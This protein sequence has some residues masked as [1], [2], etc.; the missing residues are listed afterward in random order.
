MKIPQVWNTVLFVQLSNDREDFHLLITTYWHL[1]YC[2]V[3]IYLGTF[4]VNERSRWETVKR[5][6]HDEF[7][8][9][10]RCAYL[11]WEWRLIWFMQM[12]VAGIYW[13][14]LIKKPFGQK[15]MSNLTI[16][17]V[18]SSRT[19]LTWRWRKCPK[20][21]FFVLQLWPVWGANPTCCPTYQREKAHTSSPGI[22]DSDASLQRSTAHLEENPSASPLCKSHVRR[23]HIHVGVCGGDEATSA[24]VIT[25]S[26]IDTTWLQSAT[27]TE[28]RRHLFIGFTGEQ[29][30]LS[31]QWLQALQEQQYFHPADLNTLKLCMLCFLSSVLKISLKS[32]MDLWCQQQASIMSE[33]C[34]RRVEGFSAAVLV[35][36][37]GHDA[38]T[39]RCVAAMWS[40]TRERKCLFWHHIRGHALWMGFCSG[41]MKQGTGG[42]GPQKGTP[43]L[44][45]LCPLAP[46]HLKCA[47]FF[48][49][50]HHWVVVWENTFKSL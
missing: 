1:I 31:P 19:S 4:N 3:C 34:S 41:R 48:S 12:N 25:F 15:P 21:I 44:L 18:I 30:K 5:E 28:T 14:K 22:N 6:G 24:G 39:L 16:T 43:N 37:R 13:W 49:T 35:R 8:W 2:H 40:Q 20:N 17:K 23:H 50:L 42:K 36:V 27:T 45:S 9:Y 38:H 26:I 10:S 7:G 11:W 32:I 29:S 46:T 47:I 33:S